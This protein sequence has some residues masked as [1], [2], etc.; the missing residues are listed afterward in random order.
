MSVD[1]IIANP[2]IIAELQSVFGSGGGGI[3]SLSSPD[4]NL[5][6]SVSTSVGNISLANTIKVAT[7]VDAPTV[8]STTALI[9]SG[10]LQAGTSAGT[11]GQILTSQ[12]PGSNPKWITPGT[13]GS[14]QYV[15]QVVDLKDGSSIIST[16]VANFSYFANNKTSSSQSV[17]FY[18]YFP[19]S[20]SPSAPVTTLTIEFSTSPLGILLP[21]NKIGMVGFIDADQTVYVTFDNTGIMTLTSSSISVGPHTLNGLS[22]CYVS[23]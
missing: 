20:F 8:K 2:I 16:G 7:E 18:V 23:D 6:V 21:T 14:I 1:S 22:C 11:S 12:G 19:T 10:E 15:Q 13:E 4:E 9:C 3:T 5:L 17:Q